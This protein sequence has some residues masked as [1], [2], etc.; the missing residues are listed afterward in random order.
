MQTVTV[1]DELKAHFRELAS[2]PVDPV[3]AD[4]VLHDAA[5]AVERLA[6]ETAASRYLDPEVALRQVG[7]A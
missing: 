7:A 5:G 3:A 1:S 6:R 4:A 2:K